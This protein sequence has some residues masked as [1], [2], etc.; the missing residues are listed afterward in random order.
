MKI[1]RLLPLVVFWISTVAAQDFE[2]YVSDAGNFN[3][4]PWQILKYD[5][6]GQNP[7][8][9]INTNLGW[10]QDI[11]FL[12]E[13]NVVLISNLNTNRVNRHNAETGAFIDSFATDASGPTRMKIGPDNLLYV[14]QW[15]GNGRVKKYQLDGTPLGDHTTVA[16]SQSIGLD[17][18]RDGNLYVSS[19]NQASVRQF[20]AQG[21][22]M[23]IFISSN[24]QGP[25]NLRFLPNG[26]LLVLDWSGGAVRRF[27]ANGTFLSNFATGLIQPEGIDE[28]P[29][30]NLLIGNGGGRSVRSYDLAG[31]L[32]E[33]VV[34]RG[35]G[36]LMQ[37]N[38]VTVRS[39]D[40]ESDFLI[41]AGLN[42]AWLN[43]ATPGQGF[44]ISV[45][46]DLGQVF[47]AWFTFDTQRPAGA[48]MLGGAGQRWLTAQ[49]AFE[50]NVATLTVFVTT[51]GVFNAATPVPTTDPAG[52][53]TMTIEFTDCTAATVRYEITSLG[54]SGEIP[55]SRIAPDNVVLCE[56]MQ[57]EPAR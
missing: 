10:P 22:D 29:A 14:L 55:I 52:D 34:T 7:E 44:L 35:T 8:V 56:A 20:D 48:A 13:Q 5:E 16:I 15:T 51:G 4:P 11:L 24:L 42:D 19:F 37:P 31:N 49:G 57:P 30:G 36:G 25:T 6:N 26:D 50:Q 18:D 47:V 43:P 3:N 38:G 41:N 53:G 33:D 32:I 45:L 9:F 21:N 39:Q 28:T 46:P 1:V 17:W 2:I 54:L 12:E 40:K 23:G 27:D